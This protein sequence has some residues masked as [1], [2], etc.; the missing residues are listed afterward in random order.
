MGVNVDVPAAAVYTVTLIVVLE[1]FK[2]P[3]AAVSCPEILVM[4][5]LRGA[6]KE[7]AVASVTGP[8]AILR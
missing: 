6:T 3:L 1:K 5:P 4:V 8:G 7:A 2:K